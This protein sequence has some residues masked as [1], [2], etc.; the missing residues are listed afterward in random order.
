MP[1][2]GSTAGV[3]YSTRSLP[4]GGLR[5]LNRRKRALVGW[6]RSAL[7]SNRLLSSTFNGWKPSGNPRR[8]ED[9]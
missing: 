7:S 2:C 1:P 9:D 4:K 5:N 6:N 3:A 8:R